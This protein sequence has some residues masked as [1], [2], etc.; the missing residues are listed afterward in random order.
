MFTRS[1]GRRKTFYVLALLVSIFAVES[2]AS[3]AIYF[4]K[5]VREDGGGVAC[6]GRGYGCLVITY[7]P[8]VDPPPKWKV[9]EDQFKNGLAGTL[10]TVLDNGNVE[11]IIPGDGSDEFQVVE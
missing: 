11:I 3:A 7:G 10:R 5:K 6:E 2:S 1:F 9:Q 8:V 4:M